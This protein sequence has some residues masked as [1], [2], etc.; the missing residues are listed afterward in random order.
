VVDDYRFIAKQKSVQVE[1]DL[2]DQGLTVVADRRQLKR[3]VANILGNAIKFS[4][5]GSIK[6]TAR[7]TAVGRI[8][9]SVKDS[10]TGIDEEEL[11]QLFLP[12]GVKRNSG[13]LGLALSKA[14]IE[15]NGGS[16][17]VHSSKGVGTEMMMVFDA[18]DNITGQVVALS[19]AA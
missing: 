2:A 14:L 11:G 3:I 10:G 16:L 8:T 17:S 9:L 19:T 5:E 7:V 12:F 18:G 13:G 4:E 1:L 15:I 6:I